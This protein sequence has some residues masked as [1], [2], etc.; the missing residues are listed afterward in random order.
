VAEEWQ[1][2]NS[3][4]LRRTN[5]TKRPKKRKLK[6]TQNDPV[7]CEK[8]LKRNR[9][10]PRKNAQRRRKKRNERKTQKRRKMQR[11]A[12]NLWRRQRKR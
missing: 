1:P 12:K 8:L 7:I 4:K 2:K 10:R 11:S 9:K 5:E 6:M 3:I